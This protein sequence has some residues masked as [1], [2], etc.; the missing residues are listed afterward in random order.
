MIFHLRTRG[1]G[2]TLAPNDLQFNFGIATFRLYNES[3]IRTNQMITK[4]TSI[5][6]FASRTIKGSTD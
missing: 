4:A 1:V 5:S 6:F 3:C 2:E